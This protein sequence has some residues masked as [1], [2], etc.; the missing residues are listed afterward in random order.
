M[1]EYGDKV[2]Y[3]GERALI[4][5]TDGP[6]RDDEEV[7]YHIHIYRAGTPGRTVSA[8]DLEWGWYS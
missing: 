6:Y 3:K 5:G 7:R 4:I 1:L 8:K 2:R